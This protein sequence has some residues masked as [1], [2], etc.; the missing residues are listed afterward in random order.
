MNYLIFIS[1]EIQVFE[2]SCQCCSVTI[3]GNVYF[4]SL[5]LYSAFCTSKLPSLGICS[6]SGKFFLPMTDRQTD[7]LGTIKAHK[8][9]KGIWQTSGYITCW[10]MFETRR[11]VHYTLALYGF[12]PTITG[13][14]IKYLHNVCWSCGTVDI[15][16]IKSFWQ[17]YDIYSFLTS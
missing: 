13:N 10:V 14:T 8:R 5:A 9:E 11:I 17:S 15:F 3:I 4:F 12:I 16:C 2:Q 7:R 1:R 6:I